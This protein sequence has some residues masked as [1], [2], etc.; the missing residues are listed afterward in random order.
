MAVAVVLLAILVLSVWGERMERR[1]DM[2]ETRDDM[3][4]LRQIARE[5]AGYREAYNYSIAMAFSKRGIEWNPPPSE[6]E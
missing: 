3:R 4:E 6:E 1:D 5:Q 2:R